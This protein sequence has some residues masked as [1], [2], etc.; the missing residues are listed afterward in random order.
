MSPTNDLGEYRLFG[1]KPGRYFVSVDYKPG[2]RSCADSLL[3]SDD[4]GLVLASM[5]DTA[6]NPTASYVPTMYPSTVDPAKAIAVTV[7]A[8]EEIS[9]IEITVSP[10]TAYTVRG[11]VLN[12]ISRRPGSSVMLTLAPRNNGQSA[13]L[14]G[15]NMPLDGA[16]GPFAIAN[17]LPG[18]YVLLASWFD[19]GSHYQAAQNVEVGNADLVGVNVFLAPGSVVRGHVTWDGTPSVVRDPLMLFLR[20]TDIDGA[21]G[22]ATRLQAGGAFPADGR[23]RWDVSRGDGRA[24]AGRL[25]GVGSLRSADGLAEGFAVRRGAEAALEI[26]MS[27]KGGVVQ[28]SVTDSDNLPA[29]GVWVVLVPNEPRRSEMQLYKSVTTDQNGHYV[30]RGIAPG[31]YEVFSW[32]DVELKAWEDLEFLRGFENRSEKVSVE[33]SEQKTVN[34]AAIRDR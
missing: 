20:E 14:P 9:S 29:V 24:I 10:T 23:V 12:M 33:Q 30:L 17:V 2:V 18:S 11:R 4:S 15:R 19:N 8:G 22:N 13:G 27:S 25:C 6:T 3:T 16:E 28:G 31:D 7:K 21:S 34:L 1:L 5:A 32:E 26:V